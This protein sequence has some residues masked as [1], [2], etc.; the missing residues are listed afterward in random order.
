MT[1]RD[2][3]VAYLLKLAR[4]ASSEQSRGAYTYAAE[5]IERGEHDESGGYS[6]YRE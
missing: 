2:S 4:T 5:A 1:D 3:I 6:T